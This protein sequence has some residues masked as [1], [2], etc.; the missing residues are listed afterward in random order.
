MLFGIPTQIG[1]GAL[2]GLI[3]A[4]SAGLPV[5]GETAL[6]A[7]GLLAGSG[8][9]ALPVVVVVGAA[10][11]IIGDNL[12]YLLGR[13]GGRALL[14]RGRVLKEHRHRAVVKGE[15]FFARHGAK[16]VFF[17]RWVVGVRVVAAVLA[18]ASAMPWRR[19]LVYNALGAVSWAVTV[20]GAAAV[21]GPVGAA[22]VY[23]AGLI[24]TGAA[25]VAAIVSS[26]VRRRAAESPG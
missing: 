21:F 16:T 23:G 5:P 7:A 15:R 14:T 8:H 17:G 25:A 22:V 2:F 9:L 13:R 20:A 6:L 26:R 4:E 12:G 10:A 1:Y 11:A 24:A 3:V 18:G 19:F